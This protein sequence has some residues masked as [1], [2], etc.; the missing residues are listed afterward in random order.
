METVKH[1]QRFF[2]LTSTRGINDAD[3]AGARIRRGGELLDE[4]GR[5]IREYGLVVDLP[6]GHL[7]YRVRIPRVREQFTSAKAL[8]APPP[9][10]AS[11]SRMSLAGIPMFYA[12]DEPETALAETYD[13]R[14]TK[15]RGRTTGTFK[16]RETCRIVV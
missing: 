10:A 8:G 2:S 14:R 12:G 16:T 9:R 1:K 3:G 15:R 11:Q 4:L 7:L 6:A 5:L 13:P